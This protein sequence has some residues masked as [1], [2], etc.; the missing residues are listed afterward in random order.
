MFYKLF[1]NFFDSDHVGT[2]RTRTS[3]PKEKK[4]PAAKKAKTD[5]PKQVVKSVEEK[6]ASLN[7]FLKGFDLVKKMKLSSFDPYEH[8]S[9]EW[10]SMFENEFQK[11]SS[12]DDT[13]FTNLLYLLKTE[14]G[15]KWH[16]QYRLNY[17]SWQ[18]CKQA[19]IKHFSKLYVKK[20]SELKAVFDF[21]QGTLMQF[22]QKQMALWKRFFPC[23]SQTQLNTAVLS[24]LTEAIALQLTHYVREDKKQFL[25][26]CSWIDNYDKMDISGSDADI[27]G[28]NDEIDS[29]D[30]N[31][32]VDED[33]E[34][35][36]DKEDGSDEDTRL[37]KEQL[38]AANK[39]AA[40]A[41]AKEAADAKAKEA[42]DARAR[43]A[44]DAQT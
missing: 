13:G 10:I 39:K 30:D 16:F 6:P 18:E 34:N 38:E 17:S 15:K 32:N 41:R 4:R 21:D 28:Q 14:E 40:D 2:K 33:S 24:G 25:D 1:F 44:A 26:Y 22:A 8:N 31:E 36:D 23:L 27:Q 7:S 12:V 43:A 35:R 11:Q 42:A 19:F 3:T 20:L 29:F 9:E 5:A 37:A